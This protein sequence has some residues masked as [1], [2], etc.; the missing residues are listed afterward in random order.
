[1]GDQDPVRAQQGLPGYTVQELFGQVLRQLAILAAWFQ[2][3]PLWE[4]LSPSMQSLKKIYA[5]LEED[6]RLLIEQGAQVPSDSP[7]QPIAPVPVE[8][9]EAIPLLD[10]LLALEEF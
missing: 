1:M 10:R 7:P 5:S 3:V 9:F 4:H 8:A 6:L 2:F